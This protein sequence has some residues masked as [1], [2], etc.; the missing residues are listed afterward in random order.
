MSTTVISKACAIVAKVDRSYCVRSCDC[1]SAGSCR[2][3]QAGVTNDTSK[4]QL[5]LTG[6]PQTDVVGSSMKLY[7]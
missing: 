7:P 6:L 2:M 4:S 5:R 1:S 3:A